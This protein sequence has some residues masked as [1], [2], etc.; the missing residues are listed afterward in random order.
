MSRLNQTDLELLQTGQTVDLKAVENAYYGGEFTTNLNDCVEVLIYDTNNNFLEGGI[1]DTSDYSYDTFTGIKLNTGTI[2]RKMGYDR[3][4]YVVKYN[5]LRKIAGSHETVLVDS[6]GII[7]NTQN[8]HT[9]L[10]GKIMTGAVHDDNSKEL[11]LKENKYFVHKIS[12]SRKEVRLAPQSINDMQYKNNF[13][14]SQVTSK[15]LKLPQ[16]VSTVLEVDV[17]GGT[18]AGDSKTMQVSDTGHLT[19]QMIGGF[20][21]INNAFIKEY[22][23]PPA[24]IDGSQ[25]E[26]ATEELE[27]SIIQAQFFISNDSLAGYSK[28]DRFFTDAFQA[29][30]GLDDSS[31]PTDTAIIEYPSFIGFKGFTPIKTSATNLNEIKKLNYDKISYPH[32]DWNGKDNPNTIT[33]KSNSSKP[34]VATKYTW[35]LTGWDWDTNPAGWNKITA[36]GSNYE[37]DVMFVE[38]TA[39]ISLPLK[40][41][42]NSTNGSEV[43]IS[44][45][46]K[47]INVGVKLTIEPKDGQPSTIHIPACIRVS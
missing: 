47:H 22:L 45:H 34:N 32:Y 43:T 40:L 25:V 39:N 3:G 8:Y 33:L 18:L 46:S 44:L 5:F 19:Q 20:I 29:F 26:G 10:N 11:F 27:S 21:S 6:N 9:M 15:T 37:G 42:V 17:Q 7:F 28:G 2:L 36:N 14:E 13:L 30:K 35:E 23:P 16:N 4:K 12:A 1:A 31:L 24:A 38:P 41:T